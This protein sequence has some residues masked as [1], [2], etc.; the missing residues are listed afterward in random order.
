[1]IIIAE[2]KKRKSIQQ[3]VG[4]ALELRWRL[5]RQYMQIIQAR[6]NR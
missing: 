5:Q 1:M 4:L 2:K 6:R 3:K